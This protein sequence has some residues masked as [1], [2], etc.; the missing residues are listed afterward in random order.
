[1]D[2]KIEKY[3]LAQP[4]GRQ[5]VLKVIHAIIIDEDKTVVAVVEPMMGKEMIIYKG[6]GVMKYGLAGVKNYMSLHVMPIYGSEKL[7][8]KYKALLSKASFQKGCINFDNAEQMPVA[9][10]RQLMA[11]CAKVDLLKMKEEFLKGKKVK[12]K[13]KG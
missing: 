7:Y 1:M 13:P 5:A 10:V 11:D 6:K 3:I 8:A 9:T 12:G 2:P 4:G